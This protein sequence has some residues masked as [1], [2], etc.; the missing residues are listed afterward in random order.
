MGNFIIKI[1]FMKRLKIMT[2]KEIVKVHIGSYLQL[3]SKSN[4]FI[5]ENMI[6]CP[7]IHTESRVLGLVILHSA[8]SSFPKEFSALAYCFKLPGA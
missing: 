4:R 6:C 8:N 5:P 7:R 3:Y 2:H 1:F